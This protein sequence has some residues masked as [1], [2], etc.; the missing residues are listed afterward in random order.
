MRDFIFL[1]YASLTFAVHK[2]TAS[3]RALPQVYILGAPKCGTTY[4]S[5]LLRTHPNFVAP[6]LQMKELEFLQ[7]IRHFSENKQRGLMRI[8]VDVL[9]GKF[10]GEH[11]YR[12]FFPLKS[13]LSKLRKM[14]GVDGITADSSAIYLYCSNAARRIRALTPNAKLIIMLRNPVDRAYSEYNMMSQIGRDGRSFEEA[15]HDDLNGVSKNDYVIDTY[16]RRGIYEPY[17]RMYFDLFGRD[18]I[19]VIQS[20]FFFNNTAQTMN[21]VLQFLQLPQNPVAV[22]SPSIFKHQGTYSKRMR[23]ETRQFLQEY[24]RTYNESLFALLGVDPGWNIPKVVQ[25]A[26]QDA[27]S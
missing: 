20:E 4:L 27:Q 8:L 10:N 15:L 22:D 3:F 24:Y 19:M 18:Q 6:I 17:V 11:S 7:D 1:T 9:I 23:E 25:Q 2:L 14:T 16:I 5:E 13:K 26:E 21:D 12:K